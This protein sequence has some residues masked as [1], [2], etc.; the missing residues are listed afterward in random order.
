MF[1]GE[2]QNVTLS[3]ASE[4]LS[5]IFDKFGDSAKITKKPDGTYEANIKV[6]VSRPFFA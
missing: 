3:V 5:D 2:L 4:M 6:Q 1:G